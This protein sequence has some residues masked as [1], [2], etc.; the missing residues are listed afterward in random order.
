LHDVGKIG[1]SDIILLKRGRHSD[2]ETRVMRTHVPLGVEILSKSEWLHNARDVVESHHEKYNGTGYPRGLVGA[3]IPLSARIFAIADVFDA[4]VSRRPYKEPLDFEEA[5]RMLA[6]E[7]GRHFDPSLL[8]AFERIARMAYAG[9]NGADE[10]LVVRVL[11][12]VVT[13][14]FFD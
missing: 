10:A 3:A 13:R 6:R 5:M 2:E 7:R 8:D 1:V 9:I 14:Y 11:D 12:E 4:L